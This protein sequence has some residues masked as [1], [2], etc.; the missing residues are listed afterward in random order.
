MTDINKTLHTLNCTVRDYPA[1]LQRLLLCASADDSLLLIEN[2][3]YNLT[4]AT[5][6][7]AISRSQL[8]LYCLNADLLARGL[9]NMP[10]DSATVVDE[11]GFVELACSHQKVISW[12][13]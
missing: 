10:M 13:V 5:A 8:K 3:V 11:N 7:A 12:F 9:S 2:G 4:D 6:L 1:T